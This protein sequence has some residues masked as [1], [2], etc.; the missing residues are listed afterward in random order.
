MLHAFARLRSALGSTARRARSGDRGGELGGFRQWGPNFFRYVLV[1]LSQQD[2][3]KRSTYTKRTN[4]I[5]CPRADTTTPPSQGCSMFSGSRRTPPLG[6]VPDWQIRHVGCKGH[7]PSAALFS[8][9]SEGFLGP[10]VCVYYYYHTRYYLAARTSSPDNVL[11][12][13]RLDSNTKQAQTGGCCFFPHPRMPTSW[14]TGLDS[15]YVPLG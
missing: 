11:R 10:L 6:R 4:I 12:G 8:G 14:T 3:A 15:M 13:G 2:S 1:R 5:R 9:Y 7:R